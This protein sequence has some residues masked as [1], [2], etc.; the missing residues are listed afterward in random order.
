MNILS[1]LAA[2]MVLGSVALV[3]EAA[4]K[5]PERPARVLVGL[6]PGGGTDTVARVVAISRA[7]AD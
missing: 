7:K 1:S 6:A 2:A 5:Y 4:E 3:T